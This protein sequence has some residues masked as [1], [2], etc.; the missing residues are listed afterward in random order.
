IAEFMRKH[1]E[2]HS[3]KFSATF[4][5]KHAQK[6]WEKVTAELHEIPGAQKEWKQW[7]KTWQDMR[8]SIKAKNILIKNHAKA[9]GGGPASSQ[10]LTEMDQNVNPANYGYN[11]HGRT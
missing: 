3:G 5:F 7:R 6:L 8:S 11:S 1:P 2:L 4:T 9:T 10:V